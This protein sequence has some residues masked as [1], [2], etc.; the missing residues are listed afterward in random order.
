MRSTIC[1]GT[2]NRIY[3]IGSDTLKVVFEP[4]AQVGY[5]QSGRGPVISLRPRTQGPRFIPRSVSQTGRMSADCKA[6]TSS[7]PTVPLRVPHGNP[8]IPSRRPI[9]FSRLGLAHI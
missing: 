7:L 6:F 4:K 5:K 2:P 9:V 3:L 8:E 1:C